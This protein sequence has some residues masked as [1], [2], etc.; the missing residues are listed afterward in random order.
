MKNASYSF[1]R[2]LTDSPIQ[3]MAAINGCGCGNII[4]K[5]SW[6]GKIQGASTKV[7]DISCS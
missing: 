3:I 4:T 2:D 6:M 7:I 1:E 5:T